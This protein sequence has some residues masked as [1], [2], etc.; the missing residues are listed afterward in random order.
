MHAGVTKVRTAGGV[1]G[2]LG[3]NAFELAAANILEALALGNSGRG[4]VQIDRN[5]VAVPDL[6]PYVDGH[7]HAVFDGDA[8]DRDEGNYVGRSHARMGAGMDVEIDNFR[9]LAHAADGGFLH[10]FA[11][12]HQSNDA[13][14]VVGVHFAVEEV[15]AG[16][17]HSVDNGVN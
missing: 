16:H 17:L 9:G 7:G 5:M 2:D 13:T 15:D 6:L 10:G 12:A 3:A 11:L 8:V 4:F 14:V 1:R